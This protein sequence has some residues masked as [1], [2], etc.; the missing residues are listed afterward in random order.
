MNLKQLQTLADKRFLQN[1]FDFQGCV[2]VFHPTMRYEIVDVVGV[3]V[4]GILL[5]RAGLNP[6]MILSSSPIGTRNARSTSSVPANLIASG[7]RSGRS[8]R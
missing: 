3:F 8:R 5:E 7:V 6:F 1:L 2:A 4:L